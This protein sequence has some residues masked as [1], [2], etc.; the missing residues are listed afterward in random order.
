MMKQL[1]LSAL[2]V[3]ALSAA[4][5]TAQAQRWVQ[6]GV[7]DCTSQG[8]IGL[9]VTSR[10]DMACTYKPADRALQHD[11]YVGT[12]T[13]YGVDVGATGR[14]V[15]RWLVYAPT[16]AG[17]AAGAL[18][19]NYV[20]TTAEATAVIGAGTNILVGGSSETYSLQPVSLQVQSGVNVAA[21]LTSFTLQSAAVPVAFK[22]KKH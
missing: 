22:S 17:Y 1:I 18:A 12:V 4:P 19:G 11:A 3:A 15:M 5:V 7:L 20:G 9:I 13:K 10:K 8:G 21:S 6:V 16:S 2:S 14:T